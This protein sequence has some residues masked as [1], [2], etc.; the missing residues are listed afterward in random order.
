M[1]KT[2]ILSLAAALLGAAMAW[3]S[4]TGSISGVVSDPTGAVVPDVTVTARNA[5]TGIERTVA[6]NAQGVYALPSLPVGT[7][8]LTFHKEGFKELRQTGLKVDVTAELRQDVKLEVGGVLQEVTVTG[9]APLVETQRTEMGDV[10]TGTHVE[11]MPL[12]ARD[13]TSLMSLQPGVVPISTGEY[14]STTAEGELNSGNM[15]VSG[16]R[17]DANGFIV[18]GGNVEEGGNNGAAVIPNLDSIAEFR[19]QTNNF[20]AEYG[21]YSGGLVNVV[22]KSGSN[23]FHGDGF[24]FLR[25]DKLDA[26]DFFAYNANNLITGAEIPGSAIAELRRNEFGGTI[27]GPLIHDRLFFFGDYQGTRLVSG[28]TT[29]VQ[30]PSAARRNGMF[31]PIGDF[32]C[33]QATDPTTG[34]GLLDPS[35]NPLANPCKVSGTNWATQLSTLLSPQTVTSGEPYGFN[36]QQTSSTTG[37]IAPCTVANPCVFPTGAISASAFSAPAVALLN[38]ST[39]YIP[40]PNLGRFYTSSAFKGTLRDDKW[41]YRTDANTPWGMI[42]G[43]YFFDDFYSTNPYPNGNLPGFADVVPGRAQQFNIG[44]TKSLG[45]TAVN[46]LRFNFTRYAFWTGEPKGG[47]GPGLSS[48]GI[49]SPGA[50][51]VYA[52]TPAAV[53]VPAVGTNEWGIGVFP[54]SQK[55][56]NNAYQIIDNFSKVYGAHTAKFG[57]EFHVAQINLFDHSGGNGVWGFSGQ[58]TGSDIADFLLGAICAGCYDQGQQLPEYTRTRYYSL[59][60]QD[61]W[62]ARPSLTLNYGLRWEVSTPWYEKHNQLETLVAGV[63][64]KAFPGAP[65]GWLIPGDPTVPH[66]IAPVRYNNFGPRVGL[67]YSPRGDEGIS[68]WLFGGAGKSS[69]RASFGIFYT[70]FEDA[71]SFNAVGDAPF[72]YFYVNPAESFFAQPYINLP[73]GTNNG[74]R[75]PAQVPPLN[76][77]PSN[78]DTT[79]N[80][81][82]FEPIGSSPGFDHTN[83][84]PYAEH[85]MASFERQLSGNTVLTLSY[86]GTQG[87]HLLALQEANAGSPALCLSVSQQ[88]EVTN[89]VTCGPG[90]ENLVFFPVNPALGTNNAA[91][92]TGPVC[93][94]STRGP[95]GANFVSDGLFSTMANSTYN[96]LETSLRHTSGRATFL[97]GYTFSKALDNA[98]S[99]GPGSGSGGVEMIN[100]IRASIGKSLSAYDVT[101]NF[102]ASFVCELP[103]DKFL[104]ANRATRG[105]KLNGITH[106]STGLPVFIAEQDDHTLLGTGSTG[107]TGSGVDEPNFTPGPLRITNPRKENLTA[108]SPQATY[109]N[110]TL[111]SAGGLGQL[112]TANRRFF[113]GPGLNNWDLGLSKELRLTESKRLEIRAEF[114]NVFNHAQFGNPD[115]DYNN[116]SPDPTTGQCTGTFGLI[117]GDRGPRIGQVAMKFYF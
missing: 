103:F 49:A 13:Y 93:I 34:V 68:K 76:V 109:F 86:V 108:P 53:G 37:M 14:G 6:T 32:T 10:I 95:F 15:S 99:W 90:G 73:D 54:W 106:Y 102:V 2:F 117:T 29:T 1:K 4:D 41:S 50:G 31:D 113:H 98:S 44:D 71:T 116:C 72:G 104:P 21:N 24:E 26:R 77:S 27:G 80:W 92:P 96:A 110:T 69:L 48:F 62:L 11:A 87:H 67:A 38:P 7:Y 46:E 85:Y 16:Q 30:V 89:G 91:C 33:G 114:Y 56:I 83:R 101:N 23:Q 100:P 55:Q 42:S 82:L 35:G 115:G 88:S 79:I 51:G 84:V 22:T 70:A 105:W 64:S 20:D 12:A 78:P 9:G 97:I 36:I 47:V 39:N 60:A 111:F 65:V 40:M 94:N 19:I 66:T 52:V 81:S 5:S 74:V 58:E 8:D 112:G 63:Q 43:Y 45:P 17:E 25:N 75:F 28:Q 59:Y 3:A 57:G 107:P 61:S 18:N